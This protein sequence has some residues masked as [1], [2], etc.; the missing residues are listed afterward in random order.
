MGK[1]TRYLVWG[2]ANGTKYIAQ[3]YER[4][5]GMGESNLSKTRAFDWLREVCQSRCAHTLNKVGSMCVD[6]QRLNAI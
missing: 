6:A 2:R 5:P 3:M 4:V 1:S